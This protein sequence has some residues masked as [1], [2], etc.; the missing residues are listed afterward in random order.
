MLRVQE[1]TK[2]RISGP[3]NL[4]KEIVRELYDLKLLHLIE[5]KKKEKDF[6]DIGMPFE[7][8][9]EA[10]DLLIKSRAMI[11]FFQIK[12]K[13]NESKYSKE[14]IEKINLLYNQFKEK[15]ELLKEKE[16]EIKKINEQLNQKTIALG[17][18]EEDLLKLKN[19]AIVSGIT[20]KDLQK[21]VEKNFKDVFILKKSLAKEFVFAFFVKN[22]EK[23]ALID[24]LKKNGFIEEKLPLKSKAE[25]EKK[26]NEL[27]EEKNSIEV[28][29]KRFKEDNEKFLLEAESTLNSIVK[30]AEAPLKFATT[31]NAFLIHGW[32]PT[33]KLNELEERINKIAKN[34][35]LIE[36]FKEKEGM[37]IAL[38]NPKALKPFEFFLQLYTLPKYFEIDPTI[39]TAIT[40]PLFFGFMLGDIGYGAIILLLILIAYLFIKEGQ[41]RQLMN[42]MLIASIASIVFGFIF[43]EFFG[44]YITEHPIL[45]RSHEINLML[46]IT[47]LVGVIHVNLGFI[48]GFINKFIEHGLKHAVFEKLSWIFLE[49]GVIIAFFLNQQII[50]IAII[51][52]SIIMLFKGDGIRGLIEL[53]SVLS[54][55]LSYARLFALGLASLKL[56]EIINELATPLF[57]SG[58]I[59]LILL[60]LITLIFGHAL[61]L[62]L[63]VLGPFIQ[64]LRLHYVEFFTKFFEGGGKEFK[65]FGL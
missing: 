36:R 44:F 24:F 50:G 31:K 8:A 52:A 51:I 28:F 15:I 33:K 32:I 18:S 39:L 59:P 40:F 27:M 43:G 5:Y 14:L 58:S 6:F 16:N 11:S 47:I 12:G 1:M 65:P 63:G 23:N 56:A 45:H 38:D 30:K 64:S 37:P 61:N 55:I 13:Q 7:E 4:M 57:H 46:L 60:G 49:I 21:E 22:S 20:K 41:L 29:L 19:I 35:V 9:K 42:I 2:V 34:N 54:N 3:K 10:S 53:P 26:L 17:L 25:L 62:F 48:L